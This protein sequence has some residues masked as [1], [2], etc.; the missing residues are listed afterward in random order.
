VR[1]RPDP[2]IVALVVTAAVAALLPAQ[3]AWLDALKTGGAA[4]VALLFFLYGARLSTRETLAGLRAWRLHLVILTTT[5]VAFP[6]LGL[7]AQALESHG[8]TPG[9]ASGVLLLC[10]VPSTV[11]SS[12]AYTA[13]ARGNVAAAVVSASLSNLLGVLATPL[14][15]ATLMRGTGDAHVDA[16]AVLRIVML[17]LAPFVAGQLLRPVVG[18]W[19]TRHD[20]RLKVYDRS[21]ILLIVYA[22]FSQG[23]NAHVWS[24]L[25]PASIVALVL[26]CAGL[27][28]VV[29]AVTVLAGRALRTPRG[30]RVA[31]YFCGT[32]KSLA[33]GLP[34][35]AVL[36][37]GDQ[38]ALIIVPLMVYHQLQLISGA[39]IAARLGR[40]APES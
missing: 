1:L 8:L 12:V 10:L 38:V 19:V 26:V 25:A 18:G 21:S 37:G 23:T 5:F 7:A 30:D 9:L 27:L 14:L 24:R 22:A 35:A 31:L 20:R 4:A 34:M 29:S 11:Q 28:L 16:G 13:I 6:L 39:F 3:G 40:T 2:F 15:V 36:F 17:L 33:S 32:N